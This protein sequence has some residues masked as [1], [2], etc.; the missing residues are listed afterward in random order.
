[1]MAI[2]S[3]CALMIRAHSVRMLGLAPLAGS[4]PGHDQRLRVMRDHVGHEADV[5]LVCVLQAGF[6]AG[7]VESFQF[8]NAR[9]RPV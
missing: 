1:M 5:G 7:P 8:G 9:P 6:R 2:S 4:E 3:V